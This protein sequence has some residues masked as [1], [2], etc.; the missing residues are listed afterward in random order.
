MFQNGQTHFKKS[1]SICF[2]IFKVCLAILRYYVLKGYNIKV[3]KNLYTNK[4]VDIMM[5]TL[6]DNLISLN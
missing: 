2:N 1:C 6:Y 4:F 5:W 3:K